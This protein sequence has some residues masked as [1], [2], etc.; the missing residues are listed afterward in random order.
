M[1]K[2]CGESGKT[3]DETAQF[4]VYEYNGKTVSISRSITDSDPENITPAVRRAVWLAAGK[5]ISECDADDTKRDVLEIIAVKG[6]ELNGQL[7]KELNIQDHATITEL[8][9]ARLGWI[10]ATGRVDIPLD[11]QEL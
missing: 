8:I 7:L 11:I 2:F 10:D 6:R 9:M 4:I 3:N 1:I 5:S